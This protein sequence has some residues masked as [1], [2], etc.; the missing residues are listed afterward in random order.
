[1]FDRGSGDNINGRGVSIMSGLGT[2]WERAIKAGKGAVSTEEGAKGAGDLRQG[3][4]GPGDCVVKRP[5]SLR[6]V[7]RG[8]R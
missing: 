6:Q 7:P 4:Q 1:M 5:G 3:T 2:A 8:K